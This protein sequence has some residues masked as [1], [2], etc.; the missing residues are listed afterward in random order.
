M[1]IVV[2][3]LPASN[4]LKNKDFGTI[5]NKKKELKGA[6]KKPF[7]TGHWA[8][9]IRKV[10]LNYRLINIV[11]SKK[12]SKMTDY[13]DYAIGQMIH[14]IDNADNKGKSCWYW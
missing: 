4:Q 7:I 3:G 11:K 14:V 2:T 1:L 9:V 13:E 5:F 8:I 12:F 10:N 6:A